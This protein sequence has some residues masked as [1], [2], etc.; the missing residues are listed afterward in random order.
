MAGR[1]GVIFVLLDFSPSV[2]FLY[3]VVQYMLPCSNILWTVDMRGTAN[4]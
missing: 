1:R 3:E 2:L 4:M